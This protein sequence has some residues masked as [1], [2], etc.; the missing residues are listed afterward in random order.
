MYSRNDA[1]ALGRASR[2]PLADPA[3][4]AAAWVRRR[5][6]V[7]THLAALIAAHAGLG[8]LGR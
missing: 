5:Y 7:P 3:E 4:M 6:R 1:Q 2:Q 8:G